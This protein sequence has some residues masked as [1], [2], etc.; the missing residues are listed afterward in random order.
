VSDA[1][2]ASGVL[3]EPAERAELVATAR[4][5]V[6]LLRAHAPETE[7]LGTPAPAV[8]AALR[9][10]GFYTLTAPRRY[11]GR[12]AG[13]RTVIEVFSE[14]ARGCGSSAWVA[15]IQCGAAFM[16]A[17]FDDR[18]R[19]D[20]WGENGC[21]AVSGS[22]NGASSNTARR[23][24]G[25]IIVDGDW[26]YASG[27][28]HAQWALCT[29]SIDSG[30]TEHPDA[31]LAMLPASDFTINTTWDMAGM[32]GSG[33]EGFTVRKVFV[34]EHR[35]LPV[36]KTHGSG[37]PP[38]E[39]E[40]VYYTSVPTMLAISIAGPVI[41]M[42]QGALD[43]V[44]ETLAEGRAITGSLYPD[45]VRSPSVQMTVADVV[46]LI[47]TARL[48]AY[49]AADDVEAASVAGRRLDVGARARIRMDTGTVMLRCREAIEG[50]L[51]VGGTSGFHRSNP[52]Q[53]FWRDLA[54]ASR[55]A[56]VSSSLSREIYGRA[57]LGI[58][59]Q[60]TEVV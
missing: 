52:L 43:A 32:Q 59:E 35:T 42:A 57:L 4:E 55:H 48:H 21:A 45:A 51:D 53:R 34:P 6:P 37:P 29:V 49:R 10:A 56:A 44:L 41:G 28:R 22:T 24:P 31:R 11:G 13:V 7:R 36:H 46:S 54:T 15:K 25:G 30:T 9:A 2:F 40:R 12:E 14:L 18:A 23:V 33:S 16:T 38:V 39:G 1:A 47:D 50:L 19:Y 27:I 26:F 60:V 3:N 8:D 17:L 5:L 20:V 58:E